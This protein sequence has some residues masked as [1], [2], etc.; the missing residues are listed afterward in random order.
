MAA[1]LLLVAALDL[2]LLADLLT[3]GHAGLGELRVHTEAALQAGDQNVHLHIA[4]A[5]DHH[6]VG[7]RVVDPAEG[8]ILFVQAG[9]AAGDLVLLALG[10][11]GDGHGIAGLGEGD[12]LQPD[13]LAGV[14][15]SIAGLDLVH[16][17]DGADVAAGELLD[18]VGFFA[19]HHIQASH[20]LSGAGAGVHQLHIGLQVAGDDL[21]IG[22]LAVL[23]GDGLEHQRG[24]QGPGE[25]DKLIQLALLVF[26]DERAALQ[27]IGQQF[28]DDVQQHAGAE[29]RKGG[30]AYHREQGQVLY[31]LTQALD[32]LGI[33]EILAGE[34]FLHPLL[35][36][37]GHGFLERV[38][39]LVQ[40]AL[41]V[42]GHVDL[43][44]LALGA[45]L[46]GALV[47]HVNDADDLFVGVP[48]GGHH[49]GDVLA[50]ALPQGIKG[51][52]VIGVILV[53]FG[54]IEQPGQLA[55]LA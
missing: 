35:A 19:L 2:H 27:R 15:E 50:E 18:L 51:G 16:L 28:H 47:Q 38:V 48:D 20:L 23:I 32:H 17:T 10:L 40:H 55:L 31:A 52:V 53:G 4:G 3:V 13:H 5:G 41:L 42:L 36:G 6:L 33:G 14:G 26:A 39:Q 7:L 9:H 37:L 43:D 29:A 12:G 24:G 49:R 1:G 21:Y 11:G 44:A 46:K 34:I 8:Q 22:I 25:G 45:G 54:D 30:A